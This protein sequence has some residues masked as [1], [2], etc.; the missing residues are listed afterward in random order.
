MIPAVSQG[1]LRPLLMSVNLSMVNDPQPSQY[2]YRIPRTLC[3]CVLPNHDTL[4]VRHSSVMVMHAPIITVISN[5][6]Q[7]HSCVPAD[8]AN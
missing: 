8:S 6:V 5:G 2:R 7:Y 3:E 1:G 4:A